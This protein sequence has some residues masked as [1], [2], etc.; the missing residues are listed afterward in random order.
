[1]SLN[2]RELLKLLPATAAGTV[3]SGGYAAEAA[4]GPALEYLL[5]CSQL[6]FRPS[7]PKTLTLVPLGNSSHFPLRI[8]FHVQLAG[9]ALPRKTIVP[10]AWKNPVGD[11]PYDLGT[12]PWAETEEVRRAKSIYSG[13][14]VRKEDR[15]GAV[16]QADFSEFQKPGIYQIETEWKFTLPFQIG[17]ALYERILRGYMVYLS[18]QRAGCRVPGIRPAENTDDAVL[19]TDGSFVPVSGGWFDAGDA[20]KNMALTSFHLEALTNLYEFTD[21]FR[22]QIREEIAWGNRWVQAMMTE[23]GNVWEDVGGGNLTGSYEHDWWNENHPGCA[24]NNDGNRITDNIPMSGDERKIRTAYN[25][26]VQFGFVRQ[27]AMI[28]RVVEETDAARCLALAD[29]A[30]RYGAKRGHDERTMFVSGQLR[31]GIELL[32]ANSHAVTSQEISLLARALLDRQ[33]TGSE[34]LSHYFLEKDGKDAY[35]SIAFSCDPPLALLRLCELKL[36]GTEALLSEAEI[37]VKH[38]ID[39]FLLA[40]AASN[41]YGVTPYGAYVRMN[42]PEAQTYRDA[43]RGRGVRTFIQP[44]NFQFMVHGTNGVLM[45]QAELL[46]RAGRY[47][48]ERIY[49]HHAERLLQWSM[50]HNPT[51]LSTFTGIGWKHPVGFSMVNLKIPEAVLNGFAGRPDDSP[52]LQTTN[53]IQWN[54]Q[55]VWGIPYIH[56]IGAIT[57]L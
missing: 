40:D 21:V 43:G 57:N 18:S 29:K 26:W 49:R 54:T 9:Y 15:W 2:R 33:D 27:Q 41:A 23:D 46:A 11:W 56:A 25:P 44:Y 39:H 35:R 55:E 22:G 30:W 10:A 42:L 36:P 51:G 5:A 47:F 52:Y 4:T 3:S 17:D 45:H 28:S 53:Q 37:A 38:H 19:D 7:S 20:R 12:T 32:H 24:A 8:P 13:E 48:N 6:G 31:A 14:L 1:M 16:W 50:G 34:G